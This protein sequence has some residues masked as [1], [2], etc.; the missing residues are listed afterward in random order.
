VDRRALLQTCSCALIAALATGCGSVRDFFH[1]DPPTYHGDFGKFQPYPTDNPSPEKN[2]GPGGASSSP[3]AVVPSGGV[4]PPPNGPPGD[5]QPPQ[6]TQLPSPS[7]IPSAP[8]IPTVPPGCTT[9]PIGNSGQPGGVQAGVAGPGIAIPDPHMRTMPTAVGGRLELAPWEY[10]ADRVVDL[11]KQLETLNS[12]NRSLLTRIRELE[13]QG[14][15]RE[16]ALTEAVRDIERADDEVAKTR[17]TLQ[18]TREDAANLRARILAM[19]KE[20]IAT[21]QAVIS[22]LERLLSAPPLGRSVP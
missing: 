8:S 22:A 14:V 15:S 7:P 20:D 21:L 2:A 17:A 6:V 3:N 5:V 9:P 11:S 12:L 10:P 16:Q 1:V 13:V 4:S 18:L 19:E